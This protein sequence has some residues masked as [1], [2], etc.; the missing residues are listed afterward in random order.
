MISATTTPYKAQGTA[1]LALIISHTTTAVDAD[2]FSNP[3]H[4]IEDGQR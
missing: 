3:K 4:I 1:L 2:A